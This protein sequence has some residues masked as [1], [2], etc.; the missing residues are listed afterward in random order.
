VFDKGML[1]D[2]EGRDIDFKNTVIIM[3]TNAGTDTVMKLCS[4][5]D[6]RPEPEALGEALRD[7]LLKVFKPAF[8][9]RLTT[10][11]YYPLP[12]DVMRS[13]CELKLGAIKRRLQSA[14]KAGFGWSADVVSAVVDRC[15]EV[16]SGARVIDRVLSGTMLPELSTRLLGRMAEGAAVEAVHVGWDPAAAVFTYDIR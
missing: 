5:P 13:I 2:G 9:G 14:Y 16:D 12:D 8:L 6:T 15:H 10:I 3:T 7:D 1:K 4:D 11:P